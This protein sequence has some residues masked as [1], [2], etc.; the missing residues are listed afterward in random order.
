MAASGID[1]LEPPFWWTGMQHKG[2]QLMVHGEGIGTRR[3]TSGGA[4]GF[5]KTLPLGGLH[6]SS[7]PPSARD[8][9]L[10]EAV[11]QAVRNAAIA[12]AQALLP[13]ARQ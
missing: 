10:D 12:L 1:R 3:S 5:V 6:V 2:L 4:A 8:A 7:A 9:M 13:T 11:R